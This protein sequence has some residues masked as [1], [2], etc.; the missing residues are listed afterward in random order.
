MESLNINENKKEQFDLK[1]EILK[2]LPFWY[3]FVLSVILA[4]VCAGLY[5]RYQNNVYQSKSIIKLLDDTNSDFKMPTNGVNFFMRSKI[6]IENEKE[7]LKSNRL[8][9]KVIEELQLYNQFYEE[10][11]IRIA[12][13]YGSKVPKI[14]WIGKQEDIDEFS[15]SW[16]IAFDKNGS[17]WNNE[18]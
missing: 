5:L 11:K 10:G 8:L 7:I 1:Q 16:Q 15:G 4:L 18:S 2:Y 17:F 6:N 14:N 9:K 3:W 12:E 13:R